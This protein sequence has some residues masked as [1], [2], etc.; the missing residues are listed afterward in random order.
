[1]STREKR[2]K[3]GRCPSRGAFT[4]IEL[5]VVI[6]IVLI[7]ASLLMPA[8]AKAKGR[9]HRTSCVSNLRQV[10][11]GFRLWAGDNE[12]RYP[13]QMD[14][15]EGGT[16]TITEAWKHF[17]VASNEIVTPRV[18]HCASDPDKLIADSFSAA[19][20]GLQ[21]LKN[22]AV[23]FAVG[24][25][26]RE[27][28]PLMH[29]VTDRNLIGSEH[30]DCTPAAITGVIT[31]LDPAGTPQWDKR[32]HK[33]VGNMA[34]TD[35]SGQQYTQSALDVHLRTAGDPNFSNCILKP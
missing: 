8:L 25:E 9:G 3:P 1:V 10:S 16:K 30:G 22:D 12:D 4:L 31:V 17:A 14:P 15:S 2:G 33:Y 32:I 11:L 24:T 18:L 23:S 7:L 27:D 29:I 21:T 5:L 13:W 26:S 28:R 19:A 6:A 35:G 20:D 34:L